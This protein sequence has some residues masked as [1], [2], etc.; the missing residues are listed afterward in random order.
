MTRFVFAG[1]SAHSLASMNDVIVLPPAQRGDLDNLHCDARDSIVL[2]DCRMFDTATASHA[3]ILRLLR[4]GVHLTGT[5]CAGAFRAYELRD[6]G[7]VGAGQIFD[8]VSAGLI[9]DE[10][11]LAVGLEPGSMEPSTVPLVAVRAIVNAPDLELTPDARRGAVKIA[12]DIYFLDRFAERLAAAYSA[13]SRLQALARRVLEWRRYDPKASDLVC[14]MTGR[15]LL[16]RA[17]FG[18]FF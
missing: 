5:A 7:M 1:P 11:E 16:G 13:T 18:L 6:F 17:D 15:P 12:R 3:E 14:L 10:G 8:A 9:R 2:A 4:R